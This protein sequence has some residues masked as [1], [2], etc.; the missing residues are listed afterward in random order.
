MRREASASISPL[1][2]VLDW[3][4]GLIGCINLIT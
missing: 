1:A 3:V 4:P 2:T